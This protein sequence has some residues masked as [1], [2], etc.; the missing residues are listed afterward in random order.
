MQVAITMAIKALVYYVLW[1]VFACACVV[2]WTLRTKKSSVPPSRLARM[3]LWVVPLFVAVALF[4]WWIN[5]L[6]PG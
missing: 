3:A 6:A 2:A 1:L 5:G 4:V